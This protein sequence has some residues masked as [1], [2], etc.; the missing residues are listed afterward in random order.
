MSHAGL[1]RSV[2]WNSLETSFAIR[3]VGK[4]QTWEDGKIISQNQ[5]WLRHGR[6]RIG[7]TEG[8]GG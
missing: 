8:K 7:E 1:R 4:M 5:Q 6:Q 3:V 2:E